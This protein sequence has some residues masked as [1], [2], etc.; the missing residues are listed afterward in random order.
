MAALLLSGMPID[1]PVQ[2]RIPIAGNGPVTPRLFPCDAVDVAS[3]CMLMIPMHSTMRHMD[4]CMLPFLVN[5][6]VTSYTLTMLALN[7]I[8]F[9]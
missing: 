4:A 3:I 5:V 8:C 7:L 9:A 2:S 1:S 6:P